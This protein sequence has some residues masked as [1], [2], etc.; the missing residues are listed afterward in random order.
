M[1][2]FLYFLDLHFFLCKMDMTVTPDLAPALCCVGIS[3]AAWRRP[4]RWRRARLHLPPGAPRQPHHPLPPLAG[5]PGGHTARQFC[6]AGPASSSWY[7]LAQHPGLGADK[8]SY[9]FAIGNPNSGPCP[10]P[11]R[12]TSGKCF[13]TCHLC[14]LAYILDR[15][16]GWGVGWGVGGVKPSVNRPPLPH[17][18]PPASG[19]GWDSGGGWHSRPSS[20]PARPGAGFGF[21]VSVSLQVFLPFRPLNSFT[22]DRATALSPG[23][24]L[25]SELSKLLQ[26]RPARELLTW[27]GVERASV[28]GS[29]FSG[30]SQAGPPLFNSLTAD[31][32]GVLGDNLLFS[33]QHL[34][35]HFSL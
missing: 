26:P 6:E 27:S 31:G 13:L 34:S 18:T 3:P 7:Q 29:W 11:S 25:L 8:H 28:H 35:L 12:G 32:S 15:G 24:P 5:S 10:V 22:D 9:G 30:A 23:S 21:G 4:Q 14:S 2:Q 20:L 19:P 16:V 33:A 1:G 17:P